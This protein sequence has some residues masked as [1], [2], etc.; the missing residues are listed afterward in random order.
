ML[1]NFVIVGA[2]RGGSSALA[3]AVSQ[4]PD[5]VIA[6]GKEVHFFNRKFDRGL[7]WYE[8][9]FAGNE[10]VPARGD[11][12]PLYMYDALARRRMTETLPTARFIAIIRDPVDRAYSHYWHNRRRERENRAFEDAVK[13]KP[14]EQ[15]LDYM[16]L[17][18]YAE[19]LRDLDSA[20]PERL[21]VL[22]NEDLRH[23]RAETLERVWNFIG[24]EPGRGSIEPPPPRRSL[25]ARLRQRRR[26]PKDYPPLAEAT[27]AQ[28]VKEFTAEIDALEEW[29]GRDLSAWRS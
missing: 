28:L 15:I 23:R 16:G 9:L 19:N 6:P 22:I 4:H 18:R 1:P 21:M 17:S 25:M 12:T 14:S 20:A 27:R 2:M 10:N 11:A 3:R 5:V 8:S 7:D 24:V 26:A 13:A 29:L